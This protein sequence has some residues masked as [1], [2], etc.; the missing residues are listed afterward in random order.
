[1]NA[2]YAG[3]LYVFASAAGFGVMSI[4]AIYA[5]EAGASV[6]TLL[7]LRFLLAALLFFV[8]MAVKREPLRISRQQGLA[9]F[10]LG[11]VLY[12][13][14][15]LSFFSS[16]QYI[17]A[18]MAALLLYTFPVYVAVLNYFVNKEAL[19]KQT[20]GAMAL[21]LAGLVL[22]LG[23][24]FDGIQP[25]GVGLAL[26]AAVLYSVYFI[27]GNRVVTGLSPYVTSAYVSLFAAISTF[28][29]A[30]KDGGPALNFSGQGWL[31]LGGIVLF[32]TIL[33]MGCLFRGIQLI[34]STR[35]SVLST[36]EPV[37]T[38]GFS[39]LLFGERLGWLQ[40][41]GGFAVLL[42]AVLIVRSQNR[43]AG[44]QTEEADAKQI[45]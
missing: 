21:S 35:A 40:M 2:L 1:M 20:I 29:L 37:V 6:S 23:L 44:Q 24:S 4:F 31:A 5:Y 11:G 13:L 36:L 38:I 25:L 43:Q 22:V 8:W 33:A 45:T 30:L 26:A 18:S 7:F 41:L 39:A 42:G 3:V 9:L 32:S 17:P 27:V 28:G 12:T 16:V 10:C 14:Q 15:S 19:R 34:G